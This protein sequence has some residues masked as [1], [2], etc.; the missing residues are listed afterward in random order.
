MVEVAEE[1]DEAVGLARDARDIAGLDIVA[2]LLDVLGSTTGMGFCAISRV[3]PS[4]WT[5]LA[6]RDTIAFGLKPGQQLDIDTTL[7]KESRLALAPIAFDHASADPV[8]RTHHT[9]KLY[10]FESYVS[11]PIILGNGEFFGSLFAIDPLPRRVANPRTIGLFQLLARVI[12]EQLDNVRRRQQAELDINVE[13]ANGALREQ[14]MAVV[15]HDLRTPLA[16]IHTGVELLRKAPHAADVVLKTAERMA[17]SVQRMKHLVDDVTDLVRGRLG[18][19]FGIDVKL[20]PDMEDALGDVVDELRSVHVTREVDALVL[21][22]CPVLCDRARVQQLA[23]NLLANALL[24]GDPSVAV[25]F[26][27]EVVA[28]DLLVSV[29]NGGQPIPADYLPGIFNAFSRGRLTPSW[30]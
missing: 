3:T 11:V 8:Y 25:R 13:R 15:G 18:G 23:S 4:Q 5:A 26:K 22:P 9:P 28:D 14:F 1:V 10:G 21:V 29:W 16:G 24:H 20:V 6:V 30:R 17:G 2:Q 12:A 27:A 7:C 19:G